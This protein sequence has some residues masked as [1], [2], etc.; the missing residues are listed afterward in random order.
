MINT[1]GDELLVL[2]IL[3]VSS[4]NTAKSLLSIQSLQDLVQSLDESYSSPKR[5]FSQPSI[6]VQIKALAS[7]SR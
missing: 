3:A 4:E 5:M 1:Y 6:P 7:K 2:G